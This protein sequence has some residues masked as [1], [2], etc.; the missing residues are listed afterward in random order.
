VVEDVVARHQL[1]VSQ[2]LLT[3]YRAVPAELLGR[4]K[5]GAAQ[6]RALVAGIAAVVAVA[7]VV[8]SRKRVQLCRDPGDD[9]L[10]D[11]CLAGNADLLVTGDVDLLS[12]AGE[13]LQG[14]GLRSLR[15]VTPRAYLS[16]GWRR[17]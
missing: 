5:I 9:M 8:E 10:L 14:V 11:V 17:S 2:T 16:G 1:L 13:E 15:I 6:W 12:I 4:R 3:E 7:R